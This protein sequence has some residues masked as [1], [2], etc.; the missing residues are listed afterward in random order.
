MGIILVTGYYKAFFIHGQSSFSAM[1][2]STI[3]G[4]T[5]PANIPFYWEGIHVEG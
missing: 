2:Q 3:P 1:K 5:V 4:V